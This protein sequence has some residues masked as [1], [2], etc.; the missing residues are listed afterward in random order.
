MTKEKSMPFLHHLSALRKHLI[1]ASLGVII[2]GIVAFVFRGVL[3]DGL[4]L[5]P[6]SPAF[7][8]ISGFVLALGNDGN[9]KFVYRKY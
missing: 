8:F 5:A 9:Q 4:L 1:R 3:F 2:A 6:K 7:Y